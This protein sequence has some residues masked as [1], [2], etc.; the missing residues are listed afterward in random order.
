MLLPRI[1]VEKVIGSAVLLLIVSS[2]GERQFKAF[3][4]SDEVILQ[5]KT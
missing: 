3:E 1:K 5:D 2:E 4:S